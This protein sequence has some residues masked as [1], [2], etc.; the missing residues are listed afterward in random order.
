MLL[1]IACGALR[2]VVNNTV[3]AVAVRLDD[4]AAR[5][6]DV[7]GGAEDLYNDAAELSVGILVALPPPFLR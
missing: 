1:A 4:P 3:V 5:L 2:Y 7:L 6:G